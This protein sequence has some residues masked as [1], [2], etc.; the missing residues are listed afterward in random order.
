[1]SVREVLTDI[2]RE[3]ARISR[4]VVARRLHAS[5]ARDRARP[6][7]ILPLAA[8]ERVAAD[9]HG[10][11]PADSPRQLGDGVHQPEDAVAGKPGAEP[12]AVNLKADKVARRLLDLFGIQAFKN[13]FGRR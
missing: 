11:A 8:S 3:A 13:L 5:L 10:L 6:T 7:I 9:T 4:S 2:D 1:M 12:S